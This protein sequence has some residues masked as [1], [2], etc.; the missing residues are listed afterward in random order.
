[1]ATKYF[2]DRCNFEHE[3]IDLAEIRITVGSY[4]DFYTHTQSGLLC[5]ICLGNL[6]LGMRQ[7]GTVV[8]ESYQISTP[9]LEDLIRSIVREEV[10]ASD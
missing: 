6:N 1:V 9:S 2:C 4:S 3:K 10:E 8:K 7:G 5:K